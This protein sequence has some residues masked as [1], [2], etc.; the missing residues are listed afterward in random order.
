[1]YSLNVLR[2]KKN[3][4]IGIFVV[5]CMIFALHCGA[6]SALDTV[7][8]F[9]GG[10]QVNFDVKP[11]IKDGNTMVPVRAVAESLE[12]PVDWDGAKKQVKVSRGSDILLLNIGSDKALY[13]AVS[14]PLPMAAEIKNGRTFLPLRYVSEWFGLQVDFRNA[15]VYIEKLPSDNA[16]DTMNLPKGNTNGNL[17]AD[18]SMVIWQ[19]DM[20]YQSAFTET[21]DKVSANGDVLTAANGIYS[22]FNIWNN[23]LYVVCG[24]DFV[25]LDANMKAADVL[26]KG[27]SYA[28]IQDGYLYYI[29]RADTCLYKKALAGGSAEKLNLKGISQIAFSD[30]YIYAYAQNDAGGKSLFRLKN[31]GSGKKQIIALQ[32]VSALDYADGCLYFSVGEKDDAK[33][34]RINTD[35]SGMKILQ[36][37]GAEQINCSGSTVY[38]SRTGVFYRSDDG[39]EDW[40]GLSI[41]QMEL[42]GSCAKELVKASGESLQSYSKPMVYNGD[43]YFWDYKVSDHGQWLQARQ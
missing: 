8:V 35:G 41:W 36:N 23:N 21:L 16:A 7:P 12:I 13:N 34:C 25:K 31:D 28:M 38:Y 14:V 20:Y 5:F 6:A 2:D 19:G 33:I 29:S 15:A 3:W 1:M 11:Y 17:A 39:I 37:C 30:N 4:L 27:V 22:C 40:C 18:G 9:I 43:V 24:G 26:Q 10:E 32:S 42:D